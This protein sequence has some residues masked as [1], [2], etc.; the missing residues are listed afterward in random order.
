VRC[1]TANLSH[2]VSAGTYVWAFVGP[3]PFIGVPCESDYILTLDG[4][5]AGPECGPT[6]VQP[7]S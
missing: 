1:E 3:D 2:Y 6:P 5:A 7:V 4:I